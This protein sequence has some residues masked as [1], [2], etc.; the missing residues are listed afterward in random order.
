MGLKTDETSERVI[1][2]YFYEMN[3]RF[4][5]RRKSCRGGGGGGGAHGAGGGLSHW[6]IS[7]HTFFAAQMEPPASY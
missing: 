5:D 3:G 2:G 6:P 1:E 4:Q 7:S